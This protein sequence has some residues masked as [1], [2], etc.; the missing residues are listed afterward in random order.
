MDRHTL[1]QSFRRWWSKPVLHPPGD[2][3]RRVTWLELFYDLVFVVVISRLAHHLGAHPDVAGV[4]GFM[5]LFVPVWWVWVSG[6]YYNERFETFD[7]SFRLFVFLQML[8][9]AA[10]A[11][12]AEEG[13]GRTAPGFALSYAAARLIVT[14]MWWRAGRHNPQVRPVTNVYVAGFSA[15]I[16]LWM[17][18]AFLP[19]SALTITLRAA[20]LLTEVSVPFFTL[21]AQRRVFTGT[22]R[23]LPERFGLF[24][25]IVLG[26]SLVGVVNGLADVGA[27]SFA[28]L[29]RFLLGFLV[30]FGLWWVYFDN[31]GRR[32]P[33][34]NGGSVQL[35]AWVYLHLPLVM[36]VTA[37]GAMLAHVVELQGQV[38]EQSVRWIL[39]GGFALCYLCMAGLE[40][41]LT[42][43]DPPLVN[44][45]TAALLRLG[46]AAAALLL[47]LLKG[48]LPWMVVGLVTLHLVQMGVG[49]RAWFGSAH[50]GRED[51]H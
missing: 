33:A 24:V 48:P 2:T 41:T 30:G 28:T 23:K 43:E 42:P 18:S 29:L 12:T 37:V 3:A 8:A 27:F 16:A 49:V 6:T 9:V 46:V 44:P 17:L 11:A 39:A 7:L 47:P 15:S 31:I 5:L 35:T 38:P 19:A 40:F 32:E 25:L 36:G 51:L 50:A 45:V 10:I 21:R 4:K 20:A 22:A 14:L 13:T 34:G 1:S 26:E